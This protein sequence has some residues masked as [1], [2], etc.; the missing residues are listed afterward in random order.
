MDKALFYHIADVIQYNRSWIEVTDTHDTIDWSYLLDGEFHHIRYQVITL[1]NY[2]N[3]YCWQKPHIWKVNEHDLA[4]G[5][6][7]LI[8]HDPSAKLRI[9][10]LSLKCKDVEYIIQKATHEILKLELYEFEY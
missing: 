10:S 7:K 4:E 5:V 8:E 9:D 6:R 3:K 2:R 1:H